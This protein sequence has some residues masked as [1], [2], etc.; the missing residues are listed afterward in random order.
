MVPRISRG[1][2]DSFALPP[3][4]IPAGSRPGTV[5]LRDLDVESRLFSVRHARPRFPE[6]RCSL[7]T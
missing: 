5:A 2:A 6:K 4:V 1:G 7:E 3:A